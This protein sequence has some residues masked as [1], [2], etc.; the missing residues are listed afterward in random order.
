M[1][2]RPLAGPPYSSEESAK[3]S[4]VIECREWT[5]RAQAVCSSLFHE[6]VGKDVIL[7]RL[8]VSVVLN[9]K[10]QDGVHSLEGWDENCL[11]ILILFCLFWT[12]ISNIQWR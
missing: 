10:V 4:I 12:Y 7:L 1:F 2:L 9:L 8:M 5:E 11:L 6:I 3:W